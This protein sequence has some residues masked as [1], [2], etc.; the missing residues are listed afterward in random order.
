MLLQTS[1]ALTRV[2]KSS[3]AFLSFQRFPGYREE[4]KRCEYLHQKLSHI[5]GLIT[6]YDQA[7]G[8]C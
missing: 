5:K 7:Q 1:R 4:K 2:T 6:D 3:L 8:L